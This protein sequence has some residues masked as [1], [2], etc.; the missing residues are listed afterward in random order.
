MSAK[1][2]IVRGASMYEGKQG[3]TY[4]GGVS[5]ES[6]GSKHLWLGRAT[7]PPGG[8][9]K[10]HI[11]EQHDTAIHILEGEADLYTGD[12]L[13]HH[14][15]VRAGEYIYIPANCPHVAVNRSDRPMVAVIARTDPNEQ[16]SVV[17]L[18]ELESK[19]PS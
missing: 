8:R 13:D 9:T 18:P 15:V 19:V 16:E 7:I 11:H 4:A 6:T 17:L 14:D 3:P 2:V 12:G 5:A 1:A 10:A